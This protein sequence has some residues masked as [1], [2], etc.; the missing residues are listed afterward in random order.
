MASPI[1]INIDLAPLLAE[2]EDL[3]SVKTNNIAKTILQ[4]V[5]IELYRNWIDAASKQLHATRF[6]YVKS[7][8]IVELGEYTKAIVLHGALPNMIE[9]GATPFDMKA[10]FSKSAKIKLNKKGGWYLTIPFRIATP[11]AIGEAESFVD[12]MPQEIYDLVKKK[13]G[14]ITVP[15]GSPAIKANPLLQS[16]LPANYQALGERKTIMDGMN[17]LFDSYKHK[18]AIF[19]GLQKST[20]IYENAVQ[21]NYNTF[22]RVGKNS[23]PLSWIYS[24]IKAYNLADEAVKNTDVDTISNNIIDSFL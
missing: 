21:G 23:D 9:S 10:G 22:R 3:S 5:T 2:F 13:E 16:E 20:G 12:I 17:V 19:A 6:E 1:K 18:S 15:Y 4:A 8:Q 14:Q 7:L 11:G 24:G